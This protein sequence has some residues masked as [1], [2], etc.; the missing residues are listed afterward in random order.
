MKKI[1]EAGR[2]VE[3]YL[4]LALGGGK[5]DRTA[6]TV[7]DYY[8]PQHKAF[9]ID[10]FDAIGSHDQYTADEVLLEIMHEMGAVKLLAVDA[11]LTLPPCMPTCAREC[12]SVTA[13]KRP[14]VKWMAGQYRKA[15]AKNPKLKCFTPYTQRPVDLYFRYEHPQLEPFQDE[16]FGANLAP[17]AARMQYLKQRLQP[18]LKLA[19]VWPKL[20]LFHSAK[21]LGLPKDEALY[22]RHLEDGAGVRESF[23]QSIMDHSHLFIYDRDAKKFAANI[24]AF[25]SL[26]CAW[27]ALRAGQ[28]RT[29]KFK[30]G[31]PLDSGWIELPE[32]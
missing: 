29:V 22:Y 18:K 16:T 13:C 11:P 15:K 21:A 27:V 30:K 23:V 24:T 31:L 32:V 14:A 8:R 19:E 28:G 4:G 26:V 20:A 10:A 3:R 1:Q 17:V 7:I 6:L 9:V 5:S 2:D 25:D 12:K